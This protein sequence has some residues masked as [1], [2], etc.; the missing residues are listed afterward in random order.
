MACP[1]R[2]GWEVAEW[3]LKPHQQMTALSSQSPI[4]FKRVSGWQPE[5]LQRFF[6]PRHHDPKPSSAYGPVLSNSS[7]GPR[8]LASQ[9][10]GRSPYYTCPCPSS[11]YDGAALLPAGDYLPDVCL[12]LQTVSSRRVGALS[13]SLAYPQVFIHSTSIN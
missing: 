4:A 1:R 6:V 7:P 11:V 9:P 12:H 13:Y 8:R 5:L 3:G 10:T 2:N